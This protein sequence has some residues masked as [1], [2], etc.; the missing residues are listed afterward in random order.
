MKEIDMVQA[1]ARFPA[2]SLDS[3][4]LNRPHHEKHILQNPQYH[5]VAEMS[6]GM[7]GS[8]QKLK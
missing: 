6:F 2:V 5:P 3:L 7:V 1:L 4:E 8:S